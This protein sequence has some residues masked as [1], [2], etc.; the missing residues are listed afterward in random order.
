MEF[1]NQL[2]LVKE[3]LM[4]YAMCSDIN[5]LIKLFYQNNNNF[6]EDSK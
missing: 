5:Q 4:K 2:C 6:G 1:Q 3:E